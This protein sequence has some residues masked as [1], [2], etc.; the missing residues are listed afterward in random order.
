MLAKVDKDIQTNQEIQENAPLYYC[1]ASA[2]SPLSLWPRKV[3]LRLDARTRTKL[4]LSEHVT[5]SKLRCSGDKLKK[6]CY[7]RSE[8]SPP[9]PPPSKRLARDTARQSLPCVPAHPLVTCPLATPSLILDHTLAGSALTNDLLQEMEAGGRIEM[10]AGGRIISLCSPQSC[11]PPPSLL[12]ASIFSSRLHL[13]PVSSAAA[14]S[15]A[16][17]HLHGSPRTTAPSRPNLLLVVHPHTHQVQ[18]QDHP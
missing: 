14:D 16:T 12:P 18:Q 2:C 7:V 10:E 17:S 15:D 3:K 5:P 6:K 9:A 8:F 11:L 13:C 1:N 4:I